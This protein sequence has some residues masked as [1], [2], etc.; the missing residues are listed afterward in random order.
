M[1]RMIG[2]LTICLAFVMITAGCGSPGDAKNSAEI[3]EWQYKDVRK[4]VNMQAYC[5]R[6]FGT[7]FNAAHL[8]NGNW[9]C[10]TSPHNTRPISVVEAC[11]WQQSTNR[12]VFDRGAAAWYCLVSQQVWVP[13]RVGV[14]MDAYCK[15]QYGQGFASRVIGS[16]VGDWVCQAANPND[17]R[18]INVKQACLWQHNTSVVGY[19]NVNDPGSWYC[20]K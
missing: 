18:P 4:G 13:V 10:Q 1:K 15:R 5:Q 7:T 16:T 2:L 6:K 12:V 14:N 19:T 17:R 3:K 8:G 11:T 20:E 9:V